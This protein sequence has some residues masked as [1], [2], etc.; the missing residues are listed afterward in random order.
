MDNLAVL[1]ELADSMRETINTGVKAGLA[2]AEAGKG[3]VLNDDYITD[4]KQEL[5]ARIDA[6]KNS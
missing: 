1:F 6:K 2:D 4:L 3:K 5:Q